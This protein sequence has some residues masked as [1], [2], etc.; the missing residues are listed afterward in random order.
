MKR[1]SD[2]LIGSH[3]G[4]TRGD[5]STYSCIDQ[6]NAGEPSFN[7]RLGFTKFYNA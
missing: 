6:L 3:R 1:V 4:R 7:I 5:L 2:I